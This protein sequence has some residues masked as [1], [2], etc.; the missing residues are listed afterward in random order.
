MELK[1]ISLEKGSFEACG[2]KYL[3]H[4]SLSITRFVEYE[5][6][7][8]HVGFG[9]T[10]ASLFKTLKDVYE[11]LNK[12]KF[13]DCAVKVH[14]VLTGITEKAE[15]KVHPALLL[16]ALFVNREDEDI[17]KWDE[18]D[19]LRKIADWTEGGY[20]MNSF[21]QLGVSFVNGFQDA[22]ERLTLNTLEAIQTEEIQE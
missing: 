12:Q 18:S 16:C 8:N 2:T 20:D 10:F 6:L 1:T 7:Q 22:Y 5:K 14:N 15:N 4:R 11:L 17:T 21:F 13:A 3:I 19:A 9:V